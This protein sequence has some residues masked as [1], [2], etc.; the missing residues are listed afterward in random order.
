MSDNE[1]CG[2]YL[3]VTELSENKRAGEEGRTGEDWKGCGR[4]SENISSC[5]KGEKGIVLLYR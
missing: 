2:P 4:S 1:R 5:S 3:K